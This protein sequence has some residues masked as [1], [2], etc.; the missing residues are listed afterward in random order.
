MRKRMYTNKSNKLTKSDRL[1]ILQRWNNGWKKT[2]IAKRFGVSRQTVYDI[3]SKY[4]TDSVY[5]I[6]DH[7]PGRLRDPINPHFYANIIDIRT[8]FDWGACRIEKYFN[9]KGS[10]V[11]HNKINQVIQYE[12]LT[13][14][15]LGKQGRP[16]YVRYEADECNDQWH[17]DWSIDPLSKKKL[18][19]IIDDKSRFIVFA[20]LFDNA[21]GEN[22]AIGLQK[23][24][25]QHG[26]PKEL[27][28]DNGSHFKKV[29]SKRT[30]CKPVK[31]VEEKHGIKHIFIRA[32]HP[33][34]NGKIE[35][36]FGSY[37]GEFPRM[38]YEPV[39]D[40]LSWVK[41]YNHERIHQSLGYETPA[42]VY[43]N[44]KVNS[45]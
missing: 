19:A 7:K 6:V 39:Y 5:G 13:R 41:Y 10:L 15:K 9:S 32:Y 40:C 43:L 22:S 20:G 23:A 3:I 27:V 44:C 24:I 18:L 38:N 34:S 29:H 12:G 17:I 1:L 45:G 16:K 36:W 26:A 42:H 2:K 14:K 31:E 35:R 28:S 11:S 37:K 33:Q 25:N 30:P 21:T 8:K 4:Q